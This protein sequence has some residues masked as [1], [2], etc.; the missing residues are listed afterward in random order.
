MNRPTRRPVSPLHDLGLLLARLVLGAVMIAH[1][2]QKWQ[3]GLSATQQG[4]AQMGIP[5]PEVAG[6]F[7]IAIELVGGAMVV[8]GLLL[9]L[10]GVLYAVVMAGAIVFT[11]ASNGFFAQTGGYEYVLVLGVLSIALACLGAGRFSVDGA[12]VGAVRTRRSA[13]QSEK[14][15]V[16]A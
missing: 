8:L 3:G 1:G 13:R 4:F 5:V 12:V 15:A 11:H 2:W 14:E 10:V 9:P 16:T 6:G 7:A